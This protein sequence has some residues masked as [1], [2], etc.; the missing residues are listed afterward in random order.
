M[1]LL[2]HEEIRRH[3]LHM[4]DEQR[5]LVIYDLIRALRAAATQASG[6]GPAAG[7][8]Q[9]DRMIAELLSQRSGLPVRKIEPV[10]GR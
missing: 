6:L 7:G 10:P 9:A 3:L 8:E 1:V 2:T 5:E 4:D